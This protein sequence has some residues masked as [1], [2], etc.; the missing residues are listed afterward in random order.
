MAVCQT[1]SFTTTEAPGR[2][3][4]AVPPPGEGAVLALGAWRD[5]GELMADAARLGYVEGPVLD[6]T[7]GLGRFWTRFRPEGLVAC[8]LN[9]AKS[10]LGRPVDF[11]DLPFDDGAYR[12]VVLDPPFKL[13]GRTSTDSDAGYGVDAPASWQE[14]HALVRDGITECARVLA[15]DGH[16]LVKCQDQV[17]CGEVRWQTVEFAAHAAT[18]GLR[19]VDQLHLQSYRPQ[20]AGRAQKH[21]RRNY[22][23][24]L[25]LAGPARRRRR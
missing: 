25:V 15:P 18:L 17:C 20:P 16:L 1:S 24:L 14:R 6:A 11:T 21:A 22:S 9:P 12:T 23:T 7:Y 3:L 10:P 13:N 2:D 4:P 8:D 19:L 5:N